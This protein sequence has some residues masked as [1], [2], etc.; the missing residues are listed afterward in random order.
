MS[1]ISER[2]KLPQLLSPVAVVD[3]GGRRTLLGQRLLLYSAFLITTGLLVVGLLTSLWLWQVKDWGI[4][5]DW[6]GR[7]LSVQPGSRAAQA[8]VMPGDYISFL[9]FQQLKYLAGRSRVGQ[10][11]DIPV[12]HEGQQ[13]I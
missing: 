6:D 9:D 4:S 12:V 2:Y 11:V 5:V 13:R 1:S 3:A 8:G 7:L 10:I